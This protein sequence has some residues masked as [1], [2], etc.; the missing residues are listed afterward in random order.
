[1]AQKSFQARD[2]G[3]AVTDRYQFFVGI[4]SNE[5]AYQLSIIESILEVYSMAWRV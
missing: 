4:I 2:R 3:I 5:S 1:V